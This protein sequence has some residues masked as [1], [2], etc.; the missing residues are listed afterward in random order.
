VDG[1]EA[2]E[3]NWMGLLEALPRY[4]LAARCWYEDGLFV[5]HSG[6]QASSFNGALV[7]DES[8]LTTEALNTLAQRFLH[9]NVPFSVQLFTEV[10]VPACDDLLRACGYVN[11]FAD[12]VMIHEGPLRSADQNSRFGIRIA[13]G[14]IDEE[15]CCRVFMEGFDV[16]ADIAR[17]FTQMISAMQECKQVIAWQD[18]RAVGTGTLLYCNGVAAIHNVTTVPA[19]RRQGIGKAIV[20]A[21]HEQALADG[22]G[23]TVLASSSMGLPLYEALGYRKVGYQVGYSLPEMV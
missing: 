23:A 20:R 15:V 1:L 2:F 16:P 8:R 10:A 21:L 17:E 7:M 6:L 22:Y 11:I 12:P 19:L 4:Y 13:D 3:R 18:G 14:K 9:V 5:C